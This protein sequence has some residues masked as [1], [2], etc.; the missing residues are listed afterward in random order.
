MS[1]GWRAEFIENVKKVLID[2]RGRKE[3]VAICVLGLTQPQSVLS[4]ISFSVP[5]L[6]QFPFW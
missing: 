2:T 6:P 1:H 4:Q 5:Q 3:A